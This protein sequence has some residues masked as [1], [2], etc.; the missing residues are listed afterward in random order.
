MNLLNENV[1]QTIQRRLQELPGPVKLLFF[2]E[3][4]SCQT[5][6]IAQ[7]LVGELEKLSENLNVETY[8]RLIDDKKAAEYGVDKSPAFVLEGPAGARVRYFGLPVG[9][10]FAAFLDD[11]KDVASGRADISPDTQQ[12]LSGIQ[13]PVHI[14]VFVTS[15]CPYCPP[16]VRTAHKLAI[17][18]P[19]ITADMVQAEEFP[20]LA[21]KYDVQGVPKIVVNDTVHFVGA[22]PEQSFTEAILKAVA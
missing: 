13:K 18:F 1:R 14:Q 2:K 17:N 20:A 8:N 19:G 3:N 11:L 15:T 7:Q 6:D 22:Q 5:C 4:V 9:Y 21:R 10:E 16:A 12:K